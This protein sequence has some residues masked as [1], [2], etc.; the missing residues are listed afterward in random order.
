MLTLDDRF[1][2]IIAG[3]V[4]EAKMRPYQEPDPKAPVPAE[5]PGEGVPAEGEPEEEEGSGLS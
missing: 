1:E 3:A 2:A 5:V 4:P